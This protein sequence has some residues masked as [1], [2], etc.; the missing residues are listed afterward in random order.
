MKK[1]FLFMVMLLTISSGFCQL[2]LPQ[3]LNDSSDKKKKTGPSIRFHA[4]INFSGIGGES[5]SYTGTLP[6]AFFG[7]SVS[8][9]SISNEMAVNAGLIY[10]QQ[11]SKYKSYQYVP[12]GEGS[13][14]N[15]SV[16]LNYLALPVTVKYQTKKGFFGEAGLRPGLL[17]SAKDKHDGESDNIKSDYKSFDMSLVFGAGYQFKNNIGVG[18]H[19]YPGIVNI[20]KTNTYALKDRNRNISLGVYYGL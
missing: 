12:G 5:E 20:N 2:N 10:S 17:L 7:A 1:L 8:L 13:T 9:F 6:G 18:V 4:G 15:A 19:Y 14:S 16:R 11:G 3:F